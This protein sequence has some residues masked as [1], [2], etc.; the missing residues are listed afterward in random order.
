NACIEGDQLLLKQAL[1]NIVD[2]A[3]KSYDTGIG[4]ITIKYLH[5]D[6]NAILEIIDNGS[7]IL[8]IDKDNI[9]TPFY[10]GSPSGSGLGLPLAQKIIVSHKGFIDFKDNPDGGTIFTILFPH[11]TT[12]SK[13][14]DM[15]FLENDKK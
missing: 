14:A 1:S 7:G 13:S 11:K 10:S 15:R 9:F 3:S 5:S 4:Q 8:E 2:N 6:E 12:D